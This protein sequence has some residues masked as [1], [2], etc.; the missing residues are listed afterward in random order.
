MR[1]ALGNIGVSVFNGAMTTFV[2]IFALAFSTSFVFQSYFKCFLLIISFGIYFGIVVL[3]VML[4]YIGPVPLKIN[5]DAIKEI[6]LGNRK[7]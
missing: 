3:P 6:E 1:W 4:S 2:A 5:T 7:V